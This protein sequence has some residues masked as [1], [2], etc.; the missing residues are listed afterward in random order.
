MI[1]YHASTV[2]I[3]KFYIPYGGL[4]FGGIYSALECAMRHIY[5]GREKGIDISTIHIHR[6]ELTGSTIYE[7]DDLGGDHDWHKLN[8]NL[9]N[10]GIK[11]D[12]IKYIN[13]YEPDTTSSYCIFRD[14]LVKILDYSTMHMDNVEDMLRGF[15]DT[16]YI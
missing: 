6:C 13:R 10:L 11:Y 12:I 8:D 4:H 1:V 16:K 15:N 14:N 7:S 9:F 5:R 3:E 2:K